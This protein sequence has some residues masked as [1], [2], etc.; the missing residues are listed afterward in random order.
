MGAIFVALIVAYAWL[1]TE[2]LNINY[3][4]EQLKKEN[5]QLKETN[6]ALRAEYSALIDPE[7]ID[8][9]ARQLG[10]TNSNHDSVRVLDL[11]AGAA[12]NLL[13]ETFLGKNKTP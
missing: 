7:K 11:P 6:A 5:M 12:E 10:L 3:Q 1:H 4:I 9:Q 13:A 2:T 8:R